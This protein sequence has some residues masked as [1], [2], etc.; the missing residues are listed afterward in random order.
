MALK[1]SGSKS[2]SFWSRIN[3]VRGK[4]G[5]GLY[6]LACDLQGLEGE[7]VSLLEEAEK[8]ET[9]KKVLQARLKK[10]RKVRRRQIA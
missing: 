2:D 5:T 9:K 8:G 3:A 4:V 10:A 1:Y 6:A 7:V